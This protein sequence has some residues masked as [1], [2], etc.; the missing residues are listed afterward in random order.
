MAKKELPEEFALLLEWKQRLE[1]MDWIITLQTDMHP[2][3]MILSGA[4]GCTSWEE[5]IKAAQIQIAD[6]AKLPDQL[7]QFD[8]EETLVHE[9]LHIKTSLLST[10]DEKSLQDRILHQLIDDLSRALVAAKRGTL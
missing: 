9:L 2:D 4:C 5:S 1:L 7:R 10:D 8:F 6:P 3:N